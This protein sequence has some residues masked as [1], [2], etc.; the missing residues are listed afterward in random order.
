MRTFLLLIL[1]VFV[2]SP[3]YVYQLDPLIA[4]CD[5]KYGSCCWEFCKVLLIPYRIKDSLDL[6]SSFRGNLIDESSATMENIIGLVWENDA[7]DSSYIMIRY[8]SSEY[9]K[10]I[11]YK[12]FWFVK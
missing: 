7:R 12:V 6:P 9:P 11:K 5:E 1:L 3:D 4:Q 2:A 10:N 8:W